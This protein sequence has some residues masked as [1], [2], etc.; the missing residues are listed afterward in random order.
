MAFSTHSIDSS[1]RLPT[2]QVC[3]LRVLFHEGQSMIVG[4]T[5]S[6]PGVEAVC[7]RKL[8]G[9]VDEE[10][11][12][13]DAAWEIAAAIRFSHDWQGK[14]ADRRRE[15][16]VRVLWSD[17]ALVVKFLVHFQSITVFTDAE[18]SGRR[19]HLW[20]RDVVEVFLQPNGFEPHRY[21]EFEVSPNGFWIDLEIRPEEKRDLQSR[22]K[23]RVNVDQKNRTWTAMLV[24]PM[25]SL[26]ARFDPAKAWRANFYRIEGA[27]E[28][29]FYSAW[30]PTGTAVPNFHVPEAFGPLLFK[31]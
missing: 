10:G 3:W 23:R 21:H 8:A 20:D 12:P 7:A 18:P 2:E 13:A 9:P 25:K 17:D 16:E 28:P 24:L 31:S 11:F 29:R 30:R 5:G 22:L 1:A 14:N 6:V 4:K 15:T 26:T 27:S 19:D